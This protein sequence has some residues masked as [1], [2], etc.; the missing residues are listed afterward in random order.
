MR[1]EIQK[2]VLVM[3]REAVVR[4]G[5]CRLPGS[6]PGLTT[7]RPVTLGKALNVFVFQFSLVDHGD[8]IST[9]RLGSL[10]TIN[11]LRSVKCQALGLAHRVS[12]Y[13]S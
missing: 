10:R 9:P 6:Y 4:K 3:R 11:D 8:D 12:H 5:L 13:C 2:S 1:E 7:G